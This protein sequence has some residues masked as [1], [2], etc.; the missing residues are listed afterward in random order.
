MAIRREFQADH[1]RRSCRS[2]SAG[3]AD[4]RWSVS[5]DTSSLVR[6]PISYVDEWL[7]DRMTSLSSRSMACAV[8]KM[9][10]DASTPQMRFD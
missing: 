4:V 1:G 8:G 9:R 2:S 3:D 5:I 7:S 6:M 10:G